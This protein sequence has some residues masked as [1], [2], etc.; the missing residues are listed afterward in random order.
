MNWTV[1]IAAI[2]FLAL[3]LAAVGLWQRAIHRASHG[4]PGGPARDLRGQGEG[5]PIAQHPQINSLLC[6]GCSCCVRAC[7]EHGA[8]AIVEG[9]SRLVD[10]A[11]CVGHGYCAQ[12]CPVGAVRVGLGDLSSRDDIPALSDDLE[13]SIAGVF[14]CGELAGVGLI[15]NAIDQGRRA[16]EAIDRS[17]HDRGLA[18]G[19]QDPVDVLVVGAGPAGI[20]A[21]LCSR[22]LGLSHTTIDQDD[23]GGTVRK[24][25]RNKLTLTQPMKLPLH[26]RLRRTE[27]TKE[28]LIELWE[29][30][31]QKA[32]EQIRHGV[33][34]LGLECL[35]DGT[36]TATTSEGPLHSRTLILALGRRG[37]PR[38]L[39]V[40]GEESERVL[41]SLTDATTHRNE[42]LL[43]VGGG[44]SAVEAA[45]AL[46]E[47]QGNRVTLSY[48]K[49][50]FFRLKARNKDR[51]EAALAGHRL[52]VLFNSEV[53]RIESSR[54]V[55]SVN[56]AGGQR[57][58]EV[59]VDYVYVL[60]GG[61]PP[62]ALLKGL[63]IQF[64]GD[65]SLRSGGVHH[66]KEAHG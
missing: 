44:D 9:V 5:R 38:R 37:I 46:A 20:A 32:G 18:K 1:A 7:P 15:H 36:F 45:L 63:G 31:L 6:L 48:R 60:A 12:A 50:A 21:T 54:A 26:G 24:Y 2:C 53:R 40:P 42:H 65:L 23:M 22:Q 27:Y 64:G 57:E 35:A 8:L 55:L 41:Y 33:K 49:E 47:Q 52:E 59:P 3:L 28:E 51:V 62:F 10:P 43:V 4:R 19:G 25:P 56:D 61:E 34:F 13:T 17:F 29:G 39:G 30:V 11:R 14:I 66:P 16:V 58:V